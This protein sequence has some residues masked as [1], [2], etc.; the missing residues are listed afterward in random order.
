[1]EHILSNAL[2]RKGLNCA[3]FRWRIE[4][5]NPLNREQTSQLAN[6]LF[7]LPKRTVRIILRHHAFFECACVSS[8][9]SDIFIEC[10]HSASTVPQLFEVRFLGARPLAGGTNDWQMQAFSIPQLV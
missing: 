2:W 10:R 4:I 1:M 5:V 7:P 9:Y 6:S 3:T 8:T